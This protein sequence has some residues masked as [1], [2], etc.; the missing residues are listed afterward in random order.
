MGL[1]GLDPVE[2]ASLVG[3]AV[4]FLLAVVAL[5]HALVTKRDPRSATI[6]LLAILLLPLV[7][8][9]L[10][11]LF[12]INRYRRRAIRMR[13]RD[14][15]EADFQR[16]SRRLSP[17]PRTSSTISPTV[18]RGLANRHSRLTFPATLGLPPACHACVGWSCP[19]A[20]CKERRP[21]E[22]PRRIRRPR[23]AAWRHL[24]SVALNTRAG[25][26]TQALVVVGNGQPHTAQ[27]AVGHR[28]QDV[29]PVRLALG[30][31]SGDTQHRMLGL[32]IHRCGYCI[33]ML[34]ILPL[35]RNPHKGW[36]RARDRA[37]PLPSV[38]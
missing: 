37:R 16:L 15:H 24:R 20:W 27:A 28:S 10:Y 30:R 26:C 18:G 23:R 17:R 1:T 13:G 8:V 14:S 21:S 34:T 5:G 33:V 3:G 19:R 9:V 36:R 6:W 4:T 31:A 32:V 25:G 12:G 29:G 22:R 11:V 35:L 38:A 2:I 7:G